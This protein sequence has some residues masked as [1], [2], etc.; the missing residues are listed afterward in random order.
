MYSQNVTVTP[1][2]FASNQL[3]SSRRLVVNRQLK[4]RLR[5]LYALHLHNLLFNRQ[6][7]EKNVRRCQLSTMQQAITELHQRINKIWA[8]W[9]HPLLTSGDPT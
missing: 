6:L 4:S 9:E 1:E 2:I 3:A 7:R 5:Q 8:A